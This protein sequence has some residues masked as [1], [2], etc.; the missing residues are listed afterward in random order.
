MKLLEEWKALGN[1]DLRA[2][3]EAQVT[4]LRIHAQVL[5]K[6]LEAELEATPDFEE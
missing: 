6:S 3:P 4:T 2:E 5:E 1:E